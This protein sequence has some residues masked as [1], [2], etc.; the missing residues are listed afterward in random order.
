M[1]TMDDFLRINPARFSARD[2]WGFSGPTPDSRRLERMAFWKLPRFYEPRTAPHGS[3]RPRCPPCLPAIGRP[4]PATFLLDSLTVRLGI[5]ERSSSCQVGHL[6]PRVT[7]FGSVSQ[8]RCDRKQRLP[9]PTEHAPRFARRTLGGT[10]MD[11]SER[12]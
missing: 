1:T 2:W 9:S 11:S 8:R 4:V 10:P 7:H 5:L 12:P 3:R 6:V